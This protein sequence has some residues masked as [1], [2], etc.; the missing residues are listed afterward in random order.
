MKNQNLQIVH[1]HHVGETQEYYMSV[2]ELEWVEV[3]LPS[4]S[5]VSKSDSTAQSSTK[6]RMRGSIKWALEAILGLKATESL[7]MASA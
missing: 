4:L 3:E 7:E 6:S 1:Y 5:D 2:L